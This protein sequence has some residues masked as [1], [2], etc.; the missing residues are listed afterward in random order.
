MILP[1]IKMLEANV[2]PGSLVATAEITGKVHFPGI[3]P[4]S[5][6]ASIL[7]LVSAAGG[8]QESANLEIGEVSRINQRASGSEREHIRFSLQKALSGSESQNVAIQPKDVVNVF[9]QSNW[10][11]ES[12]IT[13]GGEVVYPGTYTIKDGEGLAAVIARAGGLTKFAAPEGAFFA[14]ESLRELEQKQAR[15]LAQNLSKELAFKSISN[16]FGSVAV[17]EVQDLVSKLT[18][19]E[20]VG[21][22]IIDLDRILSDENY[23]VQVEDGDQLLVPTLRG[24]VSVVGEVQVAT[25]HIYNEGWLLED[26]LKSSGG[27]RAQADSD[28]VYVIR[29]N[30]L[31]DIPDSSW[32]GGEDTLIA[33]GDTIVVPIDASY[34]DRLTLWEKS[35]S[36]FYQLTVGLAALA[37]F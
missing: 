4:I 16:S 33:P 22:L 36:I 13:L 23:D 3:Y 26:Y 21:R 27:L 37:S 29:A 30:G 6:E 11:K 24:E 1:L 10:Q 7:E 25:S 19:V 20:G 34:T 18:V 12:R 2:T 9:Q 35:T 14:R 15:D 8:L 17:T 32:L 5:N 28:R 31:V